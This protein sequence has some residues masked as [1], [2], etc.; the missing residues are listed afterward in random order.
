M[1]KIRYFSVIRATSKRTD[2]FADDFEYHGEYVAFFETVGGDL[3]SVE[4]HAGNRVATLPTR[5]LLT[6]LHRPLEIVP[7]YEDEGVS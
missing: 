7:V 6:V 1:S 5:R 3:N 4:V 2:I